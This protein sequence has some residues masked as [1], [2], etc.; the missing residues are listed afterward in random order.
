MRPSQKELAGG[1]HK[2]GRQIQF[3][4]MRTKIMV[5]RDRNFKLF[6]INMFKDVKGNTNVMRRKMES[7][8]DNH[9]KF[10]KVQNIFNVKK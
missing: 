6:I 5:F 10:L 7:I 4:T 8:R 9:V 1:S 2:T 3:P